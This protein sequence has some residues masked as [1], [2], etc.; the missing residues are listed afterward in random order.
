MDKKNYVKPHEKVIELETT[1]IIAG[2]GDMDGYGR[3]R[4]M[5]GTDYE[6]DE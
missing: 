6:E 2:S 3:R 1:Q 4:D 5:F